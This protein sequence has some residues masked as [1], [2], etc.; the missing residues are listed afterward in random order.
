MSHLLLLPRRV[1]LVQRSLQAKTR[2][3]FSPLYECIRVHMRVCVCVRPR[4]GVCA[5]A[6]YATAIP[7]KEPRASPNESAEFDCASKGA[8]LR[9]LGLHQISRERNAKSG[10]G[11][12][13]AIG[14]VCSEN[15]FA[16]L[17]RDV[18]YLRTRTVILGI[19][20]NVLSMFSISPSD[21][22]S[23]R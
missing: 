22:W 11:H 7:R 6:I 13:D 23:D 8:P 1:V 15:K 20:D 19:F 14:T 17:D 9:G 2:S 18:C 4:E 10:S 21:L 5:L 16:L 12:N 3:P